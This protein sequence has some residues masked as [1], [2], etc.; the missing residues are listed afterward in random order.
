MGRFFTA[1]S[2]RL[3]EWQ[4][5]LERLRLMKVKEHL[6]HL[7]GFSPVWESGGG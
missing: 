2:Q 1:M 3:Q 6:E 7:Y 5:R 4:T